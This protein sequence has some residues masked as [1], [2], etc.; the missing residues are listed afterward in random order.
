MKR[1]GLGGRGRFIGFGETLLTHENPSRQSRAIYQ[2]IVDP[3]LQTGELFGFPIGELLWCGAVLTT[4]QRTHIH[5]V[6]SKHVIFSRFKLVHMGLIGS[7][8]VI[9]TVPLRIDVPVLKA[10]T[11]SL[12]DNPDISDRDSCLH[13]MVGRVNGN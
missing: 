6:T 9:E 8:R 12:R 13:K 3:D 5:T 11:D 4:P 7:K 2:H 1:S 10:K